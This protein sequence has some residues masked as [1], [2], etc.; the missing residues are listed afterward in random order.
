MLDAGPGFQKTSVCSHEPYQTTERKVHR[1]R[2]SCVLSVFRR[3]RWLLWQRW[4]G[5]SL[6]KGEG[7]GGTVSSAWDPKLNFE[8]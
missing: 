2:E 4:G 6:K 5:G 1:Q 8:R 7:G 3:P